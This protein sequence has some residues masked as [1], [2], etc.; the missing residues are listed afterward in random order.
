MSAFETNGRH[1]GRFVA[2]F[3]L[4]LV[5]AAVTLCVP[6]SASELQPAACPAPIP[7]SCTCSYFKPSDT[8]SG[9]PFRP[10][11]GNSI[12][13]TFGEFLGYCPGGAQY[14]Q[15]SIEDCYQYPKLWAVNCSGVGLTSAD[16]SAWATS[17]AAAGSSTL[18]EFGAP[19][20]SAG[21]GRI[22]SLDLSHNALDTLP[23][24][25][26][27]HNDTVLMALDLS[28][29]ALAG[30][31][32]LEPVMR[33]GR[34]VPWLSF[35]HNALDSVTFH[36]RGGVHGSCPLAT[37]DLAGNKLTS[38]ASL[39]GLT[40]VLSELHAS[41]DFELGLQDNKIAAVD[42]TAF[43]LVSRP[44]WSD[45]DG[46]DTH[47][48]YLPFD[49]TGNPSVCETYGAHSSTPWPVEARCTCAEGFFG[50]PTGSCIAH[51]KPCPDPLASAL[52]AGCRCGWSDSVTRGITSQGDACYN[53]GI[54]YWAVDCRATGVTTEQLAVAFGPKTTPGTGGGSQDYTTTTA[55][56]TTLAFY[57]IDLSHNNLKTLPDDFL[58]YNWATHGLDLSHN[59]LTDIFLP[60]AITTLDV[61]FNTLASV[62]IETGGNKR[63]APVSWNFN[64]NALTG[65]AVFSRPHGLS[66]FIS[67]FSAVNSVGIKPL[68]LNLANNSIDK[69]P[70]GALT[71][72]WGTTV[73]TISSALD[74][75]SNWVQRVYLV[76]SGNPSTC[77]AKPQQSSA[78]DVQPQMECTCGAGLGP[79]SAGVCEGLPPEPSCSSGGGP[80]DCSYLAPAQGSH[81]Q[82]SSAGGTLAVKATCQLSS[83]A[84]TTPMASLIAGLPS[85]TTELTIDSAQ[86]D[87][88]DWYDFRHLKDLYSLTLSSMATKYVIN[89]N[90]YGYLDHP[91][92]LAT[93][94]MSGGP[95]TCQYGTTQ[96]SDGVGILT[97]ACA[98][99]TVPLVGDHKQP[100]GCAPQPPAGGECRLT[101]F[102]AGKSIMT[103]NFAGFAPSQLTCESPLPPSTPVTD[104]L[105]VPG[106][107]V[108]GLTINGPAFDSLDWLKPHAEALILQRLQ[109]V[110]VSNTSIT[111]L[112]AW[113]VWRG[114]TNTLQVLHNPKLA[115]L[116][117]PP[118]VASTPACAARGPCLT[119]CGTRCYEFSVAQ[120]ESNTPLTLNDDCALSACKAEA[121]DVDDD[122]ADKG[123][124]LSSALSTL[125]IKHAPV[126]TFHPLVW[127]LASTLIFSY[128][129][130][131]AIPPQPH[132]CNSFQFAAA[133]FMSHNPGITTI[134]VNTFQRM[135]TS[136][137]LSNDA[138][139]TIPSGAISLAQ[140]SSKHSYVLNMEGNPSTCVITNGDSTVTNYVHNVVCYCTHGYGGGAMGHCEQQH[141][142]TIN[143]NNY[144]G[145]G[146]SHVAITAGISSGLFLVFVVSVALYWR[147]RQKKKAKL[148]ETELTERLI[149]QWSAA[150]ATGKPRVFV[151][152]CW[153]D[154]DIARR[155]AM[156]IG[157]HFP[158]WL[159]VEQM[160]SGENL[161]AEISEGISKSSVFVCCT[162]LPYF[163]STNCQR[164]LALASDWK[165][166]IIPL[167]VAPMDAWPPKQGNAALLAGKLYIDMSRTK[168]LGPKIQ[169]LV[170]V[171]SG[172]LDVDG[173]DGSAITPPVMYDNPRVAVDSNTDYT[174]V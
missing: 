127:C 97:C 79:G 128:T 2:L 157:D 83:A 76:T 163:A 112:P 134:P 108:Q 58:K 174:A 87:T 66:S 137:D 138:I 95:T 34:P 31:L 65:P 80:C 102:P 130:M 131:A 135:P 173:V 101:Y 143:N 107:A 88:L 32:D 161:F 164:E 17:T 113:L 99:G 155:V 91:G 160:Q 5:V 81:F 50:G 8:Q 69:I 90:Y 118:G 119:R 126:T 162:S 21:F 144:S 139:V 44:S 64:H 47:D 54:P 42:I 35:A 57:N 26:L 152:Y 136:L 39:V 111:L 12:A 14:Y 94:T 40:A 114:P 30:G 68:V 78:S 132:D 16:V 110:D 72:V 10:F 13:E 73:P 115:T 48:G 61:S 15:Y 28:Y 38:S 67:A 25:V 63:C 153:S 22:V 43:A 167:R 6:V 147:S 103:T 52:P 93:L 104:Y 172:L 121:L 75:P 150:E 156:Q 170:E 1:A 125:D 100:E 19:Q 89:W 98:T 96:D 37:L 84:A 105:A 4:V 124:D 141:N 55:V 85:R 60:M 123:T 11:C 106:Y 120:L 82:P 169:E 46:Y 36:S 33:P 29:N 41:H 59:D 133:V 122:D 146:N 154:A 92:E 56:P 51:D 18:V 142:A 70:A 168:K 45:D 171:L 9:L 74:A 148:F 71:H 7:G 53:D 23:T 20:P 117:M 24:H 145:G 49:M 129:S 86:G 62:T 158:V 151:S 149:D 165:K 116:P 27:P 140:I 159:D 77:T 166:P 3:P 109:N